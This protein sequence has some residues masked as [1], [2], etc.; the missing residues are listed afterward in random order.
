MKKYLALLLALVMVFAV[1]CPSAFAAK[2]VEVTIFNSKMEIQSQLEEM[3]SE[4]NDNHKDIEIE[5]YYSSDTV[6][7]HMSTKYASNDPYVIAMVDAKDIYSLGPDHA[8]DMSDQDWVKDTTQAITV[9]GKVLGFPVCVEARGILYNADAIEAA[10][11]EAFDP[12][13]V[14]TTEDLQA[15]IDKLIAGGMETP[16]GLQKEDWSLGAH[17]FAEIYEQQDDPDAFIAGIKDGSVKLME[18]PV[19]TAMMD[20]FDVLMANNYA[21]ASPI[22]AEREITEM[23]LAEG[24]LAFKYGGNWDW[25]NIKEFDYSENLGMMPVPSA[26]E[27]YNEKLVGGGSK[28]FFIDNSVSAEQQEAAKQFLNWLVYDEEGQDFLVNTCALVPAFSNITLP[29][30]DPLGASVKSFA[31]TGALTANYNYLPDDHYAKIGAEFQKYLAGQTDR[32][33]FADAVT[34]YWATA[35]VGAH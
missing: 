16:V 22:S 12:T 27:G 26:L 2:A 10:T 8:I 7:A 31:D 4:W 33:G 18:D 25:S 3:A 19:F 6:A 32:A 1:A 5:V 29:V 23:M 21:K 15:I 24:D 11:G 13:A 30:S 14:K 34:A 28:Y 35:E 20:T 9:D 17:Y